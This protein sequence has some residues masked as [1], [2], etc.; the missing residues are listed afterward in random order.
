MTRSRSID[1]GETSNST[2]ANVFRGQSHA[3]NDASAAIRP[4]LSLG[5]VPLQNP[6]FGSADAPLSTSERSRS[7]PAV[8][9]HVDRQTSEQGDDILQTGP[10]ANNA[11]AQLAAKPAVTSRSVT[12]SSQSVDWLALDTFG[13]KLGTCTANSQNGSTNARPISENLVR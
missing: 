11:Q 8:R 2:E 3:R 7:C 9:I 13:E 1:S 6:L 5:Q 10:D 4:A 12:H